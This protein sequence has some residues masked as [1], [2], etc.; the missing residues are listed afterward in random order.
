MR[1]NTLVSRAGSHAGRGFRYQDAVAASL[2]ILAWSGASQYGLVIPEG[3][4]D[5]EL[6]SQAGREL[7]QVKSRRDHRGPFAAPD[8]GRYL[9]ELWS[10]NLE[11]SNDSYLLILEREVVGYLREAE[12]VPLERFDSLVESLQLNRHAADVLSRTRIW[13]MPNPREV[14]RQLIETLKGCTTLEADAYY[15]AVLRRAGALADDNGMREPGSYLGLSL[16]DVE[17][18]FNRLGPA[19]TSAR[20]QAALSR[21]LCEAV[22]FSTPLEDT[23]FFTGVDVQ[24]GH[25]VAGLLVERASLRDAVVAAL[26]DRRDVL[27]KGPSGAG[28]SALLWDAAYTLRHS[29][30]WFRVRRL[31]A[32]DIADLVALANGCCA[33]AESPAGFL[34]DNVGAGL[35]D[36][37]NCLAREVAM[38]PSLR[39]LASI[40]EEDMYSL[41]ERD[42]AIEIPVSTEE[43]FAELFWN[44]LRLRGQTHWPN[45]L[46]PWSLS[47]GL[48]LEYAHILTQGARLEKTLH[49]QVA[50]RAA[51]QSR[52][53]ELE[54]L[55]LSAAI[56]SVG[57]RVDSAKLPAVL[58]YSGTEIATSLPRLVNEHLLRDL[59]DGSM[60]GLHEL[61]S[62]HL[63]DATQH[64]SLQ[65]EEKTFELALGA[66]LDADVGV[67][68]ARALERHP[69]IEDAIL[70]ALAVQVT[71]NPSPRFL[72][73]IFTGLGEWQITQVIE[74]WLDSSEVAQVPTSLMS[75]VVLF[76]TAG[77]ELPELLASSSAAPAI[78]LMAELKSSSV[79]SNLRGRLLHRLSV[80]DME[81]VLCGIDDLASLNALLVALVGQSLVPR[82]REALLKLTP[83][84]LY[85]D[86]A[87][88]KEVL[89]T[90]YLLDIEAA[91][92]WVSQAGASALLAR[93]GVEVPWA[94]AASIVD[95][96]GGPAATADIRLAPSRYQ[97][98]I[99]GDV[100]SLCE[101]LLALCPTANLAIS[102]AVTTNGGVLVVNGIPVADKSIPRVSLPPTSLPSWNRRWGDAIKAR[103]ALPSYGV[104]LRDTSEAVQKLYPALV[105]L[106]DGFFRNSVNQEAL[107]QLGEVY[108]LARGM[109]TPT[110]PRFASGMG[111]FGDN[112]EISS[113]QSVLCDCSAELVRRFNELPDGDAAYMAWTNDVL[114]RI[115]GSIDNEPWSL[116]GMGAGAPKALHQLSELVSDLRSLA[117][118]STILR[119]NPLHTHRK[120]SAPK[121][122]ALLQARQAVRKSLKTRTIEI[123]RELKIAFQQVTPKAQLIVRPSSGDMPVWPLLD[124]LLIFEIDIIHDW[125]AIA[126]A[127]WEDWR[128]RVPMGYALT[129]IPVVN[130]FAVTTCGFGGLDT[131]LP[132]KSAAQGWIEYAKLRPAPE[133]ASRLWSSFIEAAVDVAI[134]ESHGFGEAGRPNVEC[135]SRS[136]AR[137]RL[138]FTLASLDD[139]L[140]NVLLSMSSTIVDLVNLQPKALVDA[141]LNLLRNEVDQVA[142]VL[143][144]A[145]YACYSVDLG[146]APISC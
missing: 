3:E 109:P 115:L 124:V 71:R 87:Q 107:T 72:T 22:D 82:L 79:E 138:D 117:G 31:A 49:Q 76:G 73:A 32:E 1:E 93:V 41:A 11:Q 140:P 120:M 6:R 113:L 67:F 136:D 90:I 10:R 83:N 17:L 30:R 45:W 59:G 116:A 44:E 81:A 65:T 18:E 141:Q 54:V 84:L 46:E 89:G 63:L 101:L 118:E 34:L 130:G 95:V 126:S 66:V 13:I 102:R 33:S 129:A 125:P 37:W 48:L 106:F 91:E 27:L 88:V 7:A 29:V 19:F 128:T 25:V 142:A 92:R 16:S 145:Q 86:L 51:D 96:S 56:T 24:P 131:L 21:G 132:A 69:S 4:D 144:D 77:V 47:K 111:G 50:A 121:G 62:R 104:Y 36:G 53:I 23:Q 139:R 28:K 134:I 60:G 75:L 85:G 58:S 74:S 38:Q 8:V 35:T 52:Y 137:A 26:A 43:D 114:K 80:Q 2:S 57:A 15:G 105:Q 103:L 98:D 146:T 42:K 127:G 135:I 39:L 55:R 94:T 64:V 133:V 99:H 112:Q 70:N 9:L 97:P 20:I 40:R 122:Q 14:A 108:E 61:R 100:V 143:S 78:R 12:P 110:L 68:L 5:V 123:E 119:R